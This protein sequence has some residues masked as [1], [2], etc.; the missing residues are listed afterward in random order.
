[1]AASSGE[2]PCQEIGRRFVGGA[3]ANR[4]HAA[5]F[6]QSGYRRVLAGVWIYALRGG[7]CDRAT[8]RHAAGH[9]VYRGWQYLERCGV[10][11]GNVGHYSTAL[12]RK[13]VKSFIVSKVLSTSLTRDLETMS[14]SVRDRVTAKLFI[15]RN[16]IAGFCSSY[17]LGGR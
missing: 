15:F 14:A 10:A 2:R 1:I 3:E 9:G 5:L 8:C 6:I 11:A 4:H 13:A 16:S 7:G 17:P 12:L